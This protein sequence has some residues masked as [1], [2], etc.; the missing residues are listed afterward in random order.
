MSSMGDYPWG[1]KDDPNAP[2]NEKEDWVEIID[3]NKYGEV[4]LIRRTYIAEDDWEEEKDTI[5]PYNMDKF[6]AEEFK[7]DF[8]KLEEEGESIEIID[9]QE[10]K[11]GWYSIVTKY[12]M[13]K[14]TFS[15]LFSLL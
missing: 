6:L 8:K 10:L 9:L 5:D 1:A 15:E 13:T 12:G 3:I 7:L 4:E 11:N 14:T 2:W